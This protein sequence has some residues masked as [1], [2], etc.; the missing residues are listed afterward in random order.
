MRWADWR[1]L[2]TTY[3][4]PRRRLMA[5]LAAALF[6]TI[7]LQVV[8]PQIVRS[9]IDRATAPGEKALGWVTALYVGAVLLQQALRVVAAWL[10]EVVGWLTTNDLR[11]DLMEHCLDLD[12]G[13]HETHPPGEL[14]ERIDGDLTGLS[15]F[16]SQF[17]L[18]VIGS[19]LLLVGVLIVVWFQS[20]YAGVL[21]TAFALVALGVLVAVRRV[22]ANAWERSRESSGLL[23]GF[24]EERLAGTQDIRSSGAEAYTLRGFYGH[25]RDRLWRISRARQMDAIPW[26]TNAVIQLGAQ[27]LAFAVPAVLVQRG[28][29]SLGEAFALNFYAQLLIQPLDNVSHQVEALQQAIAGGRRVMTLLAMK[30]ELVDGPGAELAPGALPVALHGVSFGYGDDPDV[31]HDVTIDV[32][33]GTVLGVVGRTGS[34]KST[35]ARLLVRFHDPRDGSV[36]IGGIDLRT[37]QRHQLRDRVALVTQEV[38]VLR[39]TVRDNLTLFDESIPDDRIVDAIHRLGLGPWFDALPDGLDTIVR[40]GGA[41]MSAGESQLLSFGRAFLADPSVVILDEA[42]SRLDPAT[43]VILEEAVDHLLD[44]RTGVVIAHRLATLERCDAICV[45][46]H[47]RVVE[48]GLR[49]SLAADEHSRFGALLRTGLDVVPS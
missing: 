23:F 27:G 9:F 31:L 11:A 24:L 10:S 21:L 36:E 32:P 19:L 34:G 12:P 35:I 8:T 30:S 7:G 2:V 49:E 37:L 4:R 22:S 14:I 43:E 40:E 1:R 42:S 29:I 3:L 48:H 16:F 18:N 20:A 26:S 38:H 45:L 47:G 25:A 28:S 33:A 5:V 13:F 44:G 15:L 46:D 6:S 17:L 39:T 41:G